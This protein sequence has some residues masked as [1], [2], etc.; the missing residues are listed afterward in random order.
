MPPALLALAVAGLFAGPLVLW[1][2]GGAKTWRAALD[3]LVITVVAGLCLLHLGPHAL[4]H[5]GGWAAAG[6]AVGGLAPVLLH[7]LRR[8]AL[9]AWGGIALL[10][11]HTAVDGAALSVADHT[12]AP[13][14]SAAIVM[15]RLPMGLVIAGYASS[16]LRA[17][18]ALSALSVCTVVGFALGGEAAHALGEPIE[19]LLE[20][21]M[22]G[23]LLH[24]VTAHRLPRREQPPAPRHEPHHGGEHGLHEHLHH[25]APHDAQQRRWSAVGAVAGAAALATFFVGMA[26][27]H[28]MNH[29]EATWRA[30]LTLT[31][32]SAPAVLLGFVL[33]G[34]ARGVRAKPRL[35]GL[36]AAPVLGLDAAFLSLPLL[37][38][39]L[40]VARMVAARGMVGLFATILGSPP[41]SDDPPPRPLKERLTQGLRYGLVNLV[42][43]ALP[44]IATGLVIAALLEPL[45][46]PEVLIDLPSQLQVPL[47][48]LFALPLF[49]GAAGATPIAAMAAHKGL[50]AGAAFAFLLAGPTTNAA[51]FGWF[52]GPHSRT[53]ALRFGLAVAAIAV[54]C[55]WGVDAL[56]L[57]PP[58]MPPLSAPPAPS[59]HPLGWAAAAVLLGLGLASL[60]RLG[61]RGV[62]DQ[63]LQPVHDR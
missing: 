15:H 33:A 29:L 10:A 43:D 59:T 45:V 27:D 44:W 20:G 26:G 58:P 54:L 13:S 24:V 37:G 30:L 34:L 7:R 53:V 60:A 49:V 51:T 6:I 47:A 48:T 4:S 19:A 18:G 16:N 32:T 52:A 61:A 36:A 25:H 23:G 21:L 35:G 63:V 22:V 2:G 55:G 17:L 1:A 9:I 11:A 28:T 12:L 56:G 62:V 50:S 3:G 57:S 5:G 31:V 8:D 46:G 14:L 42:D 38:V 40:T 39:P 41:P